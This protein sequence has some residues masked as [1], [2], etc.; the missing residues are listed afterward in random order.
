MQREFIRHNQAA[1]WNRIHRISAE[2]PSMPPI[3][4]SV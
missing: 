4:S 3:G 2:V 1:L